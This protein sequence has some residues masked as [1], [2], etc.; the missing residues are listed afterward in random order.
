MRLTGARALVEHRLLDVVDLE[1]LVLDGIV[2]HLVP[3]VGVALVLCGAALEAAVPQRAVVA[4]DD[5]VVVRRVVH[6]QHLR[7]GLGR[8]CRASSR[9]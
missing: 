1:Q 4:G 9:G 8:T 3:A 5:E 7:A 2:R 6:D